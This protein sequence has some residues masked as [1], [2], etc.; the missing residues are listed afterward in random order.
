MLERQNDALERQLRRFSDWI[1][2]L[3]GPSKAIFT[4]IVLAVMG[5]IVLWEARDLLRFMGL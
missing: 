4:I 1:E 2:S 3:N 5:L